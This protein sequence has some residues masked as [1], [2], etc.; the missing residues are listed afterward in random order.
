MTDR[1]FHVRTAVQGT[2]SKLTSSAGLAIGGAV[3]VV[4]GTF[5]PWYQRTVGDVTLAHFGRNLYELGPISAAPWNSIAPV[6][7]DAGAAV[8]LLSGLL[9]LLGRDQA[10]RL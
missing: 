7:V 4:V 6:F 1:P 8:L 3:I 9:V 2:R 10:A 5:L